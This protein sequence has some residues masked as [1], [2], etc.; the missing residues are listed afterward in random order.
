MQIII[1]Y[2][3][4]H[5][6]SVSATIIIFFLSCIEV[7]KI[8][9]NPISS[10]LKFVG[11]ACNAT[12]YSKMDELEKSQSDICKE[13]NITR[14][15]MKE[16]FLDIDTQMNEKFT[17]LGNDLSYSV[18]MTSRYRLIRAGEDVINGVGI[19]K[20]RL[21]VLLNDDLKVYQRYCNEHPEYINHK[22][23]RSVKILLDYENEVLEHERK[24][25]EVI[26]S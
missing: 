9:L 22:G 6:G 1:D 12:L 17:K 8:K 7:S 24:N 13:F 10:I 14:D 23:Q 16:R 26:N 3:Q 11:K 19:S 5:L 18:A 21:E 20:D 15:I 25:H 4:M 2:I